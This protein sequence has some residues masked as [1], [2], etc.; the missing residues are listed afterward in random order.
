MNR[1]SRQYIHRH[2]VPVRSIPDPYRRS[3]AEQQLRYQRDVIRKYE[4]EG[5]ITEMKEGQIVFRPSE[6]LIEKQVRSQ[7]MKAKVPEDVKRLGLASEYR[8]AM[9]DESLGR[10]PEG[11]AEERFREIYEK[12][13]EKTMKREYRE[14]GKVPE[15]FSG[16]ITIPSEIS[17]LGL[18]KEYIQASYEKSI[19]VVP[20]EKVEERFQKLYQEQ[21]MKQ[22]KKEYAEQP[23]VVQFGRAFFAGVTQFPTLV[24]ETAAGMLT[25]GLKGVKKGPVGM[26]AG[27]G[28]GFMKG[29]KKAQEMIITREAA[30]FKKLREG[31]K[32]EWFVEEVALSPAITDV[33]LP[34]TVG[35]GLG[36]GFQAVG[37]AGTAAT[38]G[39]TKKALTGFARYA[40][41]A[42]AGTASGVIGVETGRTAALEKMGKLPSGTFASSLARLGTQIGSAF[43]GGYYGSR[44]ETLARAEQI[45]RAVKQPFKTGLQKI[46]KTPISQKIKTPIQQFKMK[47]IDIRMA[48]AMLKQPQLA[49]KVRAFEGPTVRQRLSEIG[50]KLKTQIYEPSAREIMMRAGML[51]TYKM[52]PY[53]YKPVGKTAYRDVMAQIAEAQQIPSKYETYLYGK[54]AEIE[55]IR[56]VKFLKLEGKPATFARAYRL[57]VEPVTGKVVTKLAGVRPAKEIQI[58]DKVIGYRY[59]KSVKPFKAIHEYKPFGV[60]DVGYRYVTALKTKPLKTVKLKPF[61]ISDVGYRYVT[62]AP[63]RLKFAKLKFPTVYRGVEAYGLPAISMKEL[64]KQVRVKKVKPE[65]ITVGALKTDQITRYDLRR[66]AELERMEEGILKTPH[67]IYEKKIKPMQLERIETALLPEQFQKM[68]PTERVLFEQIQKPEKIVTPVSVSILESALIPKSMVEQQPLQLQKQKLEQLLLQEQIQKFKPQAISKYDFMPGIVTPEAISFAT[69]VFYPMRLPT[70]GKAVEEKL[71]GPGYNVMVKEHVYKHGKR[72]KKDRFERI[73]DS[74][75]TK[76]DAMLLLYSALDESEAQTGYVKPTSGSP[77]RLNIDVDADLETLADKFYQKK[78]KYIEKRGYAIDS[79]GE[80]MGIS[81]KGWYSQKKRKPRLAREVRVT[82]QPFDGFFDFESVMDFGEFAL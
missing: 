53:T 51:E 78:G 66:L 46:V 82:R 38:A 58:G 35:Y 77:R 27:Y 48:K 70:P 23:P 65:F 49:E 4:K 19:G 6:Q 59:I 61:G 39:I 41:K 32:K 36:L 81:A 67:P 40:P 55:G 42:V 5:Y 26:A 45:G 16:M 18:S 17:R 63:T 73:N 1:N 54:T 69:D 2:A 33:V 15:S 30:G 68:L 22:I 20:G 25:E 60:T 44:P 7:V 9:L 34:M 13:Y 62:E 3:Q 79:W 37:K 14:T 24:E 11:E 75:L 56:G 47:D 29:K 12:K 21:H 80:I 43:V 74:P 72:I 76:K 57:E 50:G 64:E 10:V 52:R 28:L 31:K 8:Q 71:T